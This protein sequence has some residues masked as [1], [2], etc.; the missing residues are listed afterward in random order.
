MSSGHTGSANS[1]GSRE[2][3][4]ERIIAPQADS[5]ALRQ[6]VRAHFFSGHDGQRDRFFLKKSGNAGVDGERDGKW[7]DS[8]RSELGRRFQIVVVLRIRGALPCRT[9]LVVFD[10]RVQQ[11]LVDVY[12]VDEDVVS[13]H[14]AC[15][16]GFHPYDRGDDLQPAVHTQCEFGEL[17][18]HHAQQSGSFPGPAE[19]FGARHSL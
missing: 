14:G 13:L 15:P 19:I 3:R 18:V 9:D 6:Q 7:P 1:K 8:H 12:A 10:R 5:A 2:R 11:D 16:H 4:D 17:A